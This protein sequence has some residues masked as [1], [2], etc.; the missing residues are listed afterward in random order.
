MYGGHCTPCAVKIKIA[1]VNKYL[2][3]VQTQGFIPETVQNHYDILEH[4]ASECIACG[5]CEKNC[6]FEVKIINKMKQAKEVF[7]K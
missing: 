2:D 3:L 5:R 7:G 4:H 6:P 1:D